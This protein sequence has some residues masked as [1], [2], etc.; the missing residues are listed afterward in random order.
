MS[1]NFSNN[2]TTLLR[3][4]QLAVTAIALVGLSVLFAQPAHA[5]DPIGTA[6]G[7]QITC[8]PGGA[9]NGTCFRV[10]I[11]G[12]AGGTFIAGAKLNT[13]TAGNPIGAV[14]LTTGGGGNS[15]YEAGFQLAG[16]CS[17]NCGKQ[18]ILDLNAAKYNTIQ[19]N[20][21]DPNNPAPEFDG[22]LTGSTTSQSGPRLLACRY[23]TMAHWIWTA[24]LKSDTIRPVCA[25]ANSAG[26]AAIAYSLSQYQLGSASGPG[27]AFR[28]VEL[29]SGPPLSRL[30]HGCL[31]KR[32]APA[33]QVQCPLTNPLTTISEFI[34]MSDAENFIDPSYDGDLDCPNGT[35]NPDGQFDYCGNSI[36][37]GSTTG[38]PL[39]HDSIL[40]DTDPPILS[41]S[42][43]VNVVFGAQDLSASVPLGQE[44]YDVV[45]TTKAQSCV[46]VAKHNL[47]AY[48]QGEQQI[49]ADIKS[50][51]K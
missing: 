46:A 23:A 10:T 35:C 11:S 12:C 37:A 39:L 17:G 6:S 7:N 51:C 18:A 27:P 47:P 48:T 41:F 50:L 28:M 38:T 14:M 43:K 1:P 20:F 5:T 42:T 13:S 36:N 19:T 26:S 45:T 3:F 34:G 9:P 15:W 4:A 16:N 22:W 40:S 2:R 21:S 30:D 44:W 25:T 24:L 29:T 33:P 8:P 31:P 32:L 49:V